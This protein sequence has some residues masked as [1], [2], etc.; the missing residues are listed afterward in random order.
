MPTPRLETLRPGD[1]SAAS[2]ML[3]DIPHGRAGDAMEGTVSKFI[4]DWWIVLLIPLLAVWH[5]QRE[6]QF[7]KEE[8]RNAALAPPDD[9]QIRWHIR[10]IRQDIA[11]VCQLLMFVALVILWRELRR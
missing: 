1:P 9:Q 6:R 2:I 5:I 4:A 7:A 3:G 11:L 8:Q 10:H